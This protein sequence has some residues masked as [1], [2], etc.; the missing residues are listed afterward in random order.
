MNQNGIG[1]LN[2]LK[3]M[4][5]A[6]DQF[7]VVHDEINLPQGKVKLSSGKFKKST[8]RMDKQRRMRIR[9]K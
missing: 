9:N 8:G 3:I 7:L 1:L 5:P 6:S 4:N 2:F